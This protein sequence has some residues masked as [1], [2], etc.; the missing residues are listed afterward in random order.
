MYSNEA[1]GVKFL[2]LISRQNKE[3]SNGL[4]NGKQTSAIENQ[5]GCRMM[6][7]LNNLRIGFK[8]QFE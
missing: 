2:L 1:I 4:V 3:F 7:L 6:N 5:I 8:S